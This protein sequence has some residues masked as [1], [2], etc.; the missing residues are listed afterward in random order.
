MVFACKTILSVIEGAAREL[1]HSF[2]P[3]AEALGTPNE[4]AAVETVYRTLS[5]INFST[6]VLEVLP[7]EHR[8]AL[9]VLPVRGVT[10]SDWGT[11]ERLSGTL[12]A[13]VASNDVQSASG[14]Q[15]SEQV[16]HGLS[17]VPGTNAQENRRTSA[18][19]S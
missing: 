8:R 17:Y 19:G 5:P 13:L 6:G 4:Q 10:W 11:A 1:Y 2:G 15:Y 7:F 3:I 12:R 18:K 16:G 9:L 14:L